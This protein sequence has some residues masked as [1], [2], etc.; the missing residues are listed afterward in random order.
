MAKYSALPRF[1]KAG[2]DN[3]NFVNGASFI[4]GG[5]IT[6]PIDTTGGASLSI[7]N[8]TATETIDV[9]VTNR[10]YVECPAGESRP[11]PDWPGLFQTGCTVSCSGTGARG[12]VYVSEMTRS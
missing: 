6:A 10:I 2:Q 7:W 5:L 11:I 12:V 8:S 1:I 9:D 4:E 3:T